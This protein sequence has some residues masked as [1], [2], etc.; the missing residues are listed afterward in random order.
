MNIWVI[1]IG[2]P[3]PISG[4][5]D[6]LHR[7]G[8]LNKILAEKGHEVVWWSS[9][10]NHFSKQHIF[11]ENTI[12][13]INSNLELQLLNGRAYN[14]NISFA[15]IRNHIEI[16]KQFKEV[17]SKYNVPDKIFCAFPA[18]ELAYEATIYAKKN[19]VPF[20]IDA[21]DMWPDIFLNASPPFFRPFIKIFLAKYY[22][23]TS[24]I[25][26]NANIIT[27]ITDGFVDWAITYTDRNRS[28]NDKAF[29]LGYPSDDFEDKLILE[30]WDS[31]EKMGISK[32]DF[33]ISYVG[34]LTENKIDIDIIFNVAESLIVNKNIKF[35]LAGEGDQKEK[36]KAIIKQRSLQNI[37]LP[38]WINKYQIRSLLQNSSFGL[39]PLRD[40]KDYIISIP[41]K[42][43]EYLANSL[44][45]I[46]YLPG[47]LKKLIEKE[48]IGFIYKDES[49]FI[50]I[51]NNIEDNDLNIMKK[52]CR[53]LY[54][55]KFDSRLVYNQFADFIEKV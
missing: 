3:L 22:S 24:Y 51:I 25:F 20:I 26:S 13:Q 27:G 2:E 1:A 45:I 38:G 44:P 14:K 8:L 40:R 47:E 39:V 10:F 17:A 42:P 15:R 41:N 29:Y 49:D 55:R 31:W 30:A 34:A 48:S 5:N 53:A 35:V 33:I 4:N 21:R 43:I 19:E 54:K 46:S 36:Y 7:C 28:S 23:M 37:I 11:N 16:S 50:N 9:T 6:R 18:I 12:I 32:N 52:R